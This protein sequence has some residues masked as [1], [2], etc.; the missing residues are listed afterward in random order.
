MHILKFVDSEI[1][2]INPPKNCVNNKRHYQWKEDIICPW[3]H[4][5]FDW[6]THEIHED[7]FLTNEKYSTVSAI[8]NRIGGVMVSLLAS[9][10]IDRGFK[11]AL[12]RSNQRR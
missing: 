9:N 11:E 1:T 5:F 2:K 7:W 3:I 8:L 12:L 6:L 4:T 10:V